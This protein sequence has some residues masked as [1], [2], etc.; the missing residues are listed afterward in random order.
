MASKTGRHY[1]SVHTKR[2]LF[3]QAQH[4]CEYKDSKTHRR[5]NSKYK[6]EIDHRQPVALGGVNDF[7]NL[8]VLCQTHNALAARQ[9]G[10]QG[11]LGSR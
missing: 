3:A 10:L 11:R 2:K 6:L 9:A 1:I 8:R 4:C 5:C 7:S